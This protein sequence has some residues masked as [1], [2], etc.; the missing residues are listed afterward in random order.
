MSHIGLMFFGDY[1]KYKNW[2]YCSRCDCL[3]CL[4]SHRVV[5]E[6]RDSLGAT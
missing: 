1:K 6:L 2:R 5:S 3:F 4:F